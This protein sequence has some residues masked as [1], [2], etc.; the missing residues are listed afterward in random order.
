MHNDTLAVYRRD[1]R[2]IENERPLDEARV[3]EAHGKQIEHVENDYQEE[4]PAQA[5]ARAGV[6]GRENRKCDHS[7][8]DR[9]QDKLGSHVGIVP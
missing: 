8:D 5:A 1:R 3:D 9:E 7:N 6:A 4:G 2:P